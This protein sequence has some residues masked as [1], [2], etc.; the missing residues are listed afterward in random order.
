MVRRSCALGPV[1]VQGAVHRGA[2][3]AD[4]VTVAVD[5]PDDEGPVVHRAD[6]VGECDRIGV[7]A[8][9]P[10]VHRVGEQRLD[11]SV[12]ASL[13]F[14]GVSPEIGI[15]D[16]EVQ[17]REVVGE[18][19]VSADGSDQFGQGLVERLDGSVR[20]RPACS[21]ERSG[22]TRRGVPGEREE[23]FLLRTE[24]VGE[25]RRRETAP[26]GHRGEREPGG[27]GVGQ[28]VT[29]RSEDL[30]VARDPGTA[31]HPAIVL[32]TVWLCSICGMTSWAD[33]ATADPDLAAR[34]RHRFESNLHHVLGTVRP[35]GSPRL[36]GSEVSFDDD[37]R[38]G[39]MPGSRK[40]ADVL[41]DPRVEIH[42]TRSRTIS[43]TGTRA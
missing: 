26:A 28:R 6:G 29:D 41:R 3:P 8:E 24:P 10:P 34:V 31:G 37:V 35:D 21:L 40:L 9:L 30:L 27:A 43:P 17:H 7:G 18:R 2:D 25:R 36:S 19:L 1:R 23:Q 14:G 42:S 22:D 13:V 4:Q 38:I 16:V 20:G 5:G 39:M 15:G 11:T 32:N 33:I 12:E